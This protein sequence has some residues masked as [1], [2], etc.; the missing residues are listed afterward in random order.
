MVTTRRSIFTMRST[1]GMSTITPGPLAPM[2]LP[3]RKTTPRSYSRRI[4]KACGSRIITRTIRTNRTGI[5][6]ARLERSIAGACWLSLLWFY[7]QCQT[8]DFD[9]LNQLS[10]LDGGIAN[11][12][13]V[14]ALDKHLAAMGIN[15]S[16]G[17][18]GFAQH[19][20]FSRPD[21]QSLGA[22]A[23]ADDE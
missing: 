11:R 7:L 4:R 19:R 20:F 9:N 6:L 15:G 8:A 14:L 17:R 13:P 23:L 2:S 18:S 10:R 21:R 22:N 5:T 12:I 16:C 3:S 1:M